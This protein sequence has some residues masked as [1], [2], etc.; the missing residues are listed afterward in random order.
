MP[1]GIKIV[2][3]VLQR[4]NGCQLDHSQLQFVLV[5]LDDILIFWKSWEAHIEHIRHSMTLLEDAG[6]QSNGRCAI[7]VNTINHL[8][9]VIHSGQLAVSQ[10]TI[11]VI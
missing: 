8:G 11:D 1:I 2:P 5:Y 10:H 7:I 3:D 9:H 6:L 4:K